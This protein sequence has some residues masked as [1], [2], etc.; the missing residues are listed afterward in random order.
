MSKQKRSSRSQSK[1]G[2]KEPAEDFD[3]DKQPWRSAFR[4][5]CAQPSKDNSFVLEDE[6]TASMVEGLLSSLTVSDPNE[7]GHPLCYASPGYLAMMG[8]AEH[9]YLGRSCPALEADKGDPAVQE[10]LRQSMAARRFFSAEFTSR[11]KDGRAFQ[12][13]LAVM[14][15]LGG[16]GSTLLNWVT[17]HCDLDDRKRRGEAVDDSFVSRWGEQVQGCLAA[18]ALVDV[19]EPTASQSA[20]GQGAGK[21]RGAARSPTAPPSASVCAVSP[22]FTALTGYSQSDV[23]GWNLLCLCGQDSCEQEMRKLLTSQWA[24][25]PVAA[26]FLCYKRDGTPFWAMVLSF[27]LNASTVGATAAPDPAGRGAAELALGRVSPG[28]GRQAVHQQYGL[29]NRGR[30]L[31]GLLGSGGLLGGLAPSAGSSSGGRA[32]AAATGSGDAGGLESRYCLCCV[33]DITATRLKKVVGGKYVLGKVIGAGAFGLVRIGRNIATDELVAVKGVDATRFRSITEIDQIQEEMSVLSSLKHPHIIRLYD[34][35]FQNNTFFL[36]MEFAG[37][38]SLVHFARSQDPV[39]QRVDEAT[40]ARLFT[41]IVSALEYCHR[42][43][44][45]H[46]DLKPENILMDGEGNLK[47]ADFGLA[48]VTA[49]FN[50]GLTLQCGTPE[51]TA[52]EITVGREYDGPSVDI[53]SMGVILYEMLAGTLPFKGA[54]QAALFKAIQK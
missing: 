4:P 8:L 25:S 42:R 51:F 22:G 39:H 16:D 35:H 2:V 18:C 24:H 21:G 31:G 40:A 44:V 33:V 52:P 29:G 34:V 54:N 6:A 12:N 1:D 37:G 14:P 3:D 17:V 15:V 36:V 32:S 23:Y 26:K 49:P 28:N 43:R 47:I 10:Q 9:E 50:G 45:I 13:L 20:T 27:P 30:G 5:T 19:S 11:R 48:A 53:W 7:E 41:Q 46:R 38:G